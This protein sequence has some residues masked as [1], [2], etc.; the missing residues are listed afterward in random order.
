MVVA[1]AS[2]GCGGDDK[3]AA[4]KDPFTAIER[5]FEHTPASHRAAPHW[6]SL[7][8]LSGKTDAQP[9]VTVA[10]GAI[11]WRVRWTCR[12]GTF[13][14]VVD[15]R[16]TGPS[17]SQGPCPGH[18]ER[19][20]IGKGL[21]RLS[22]T[23][24]GSWRMEV[25]QQVDTPLHEPPLAAMQGPKAR[26]LKRGSFYGLEREGSGEVTLRRLSSGRLALRLEHFKT[27]ANAALFVWVSP[28]RHPR[29]TRQA[30]TQPHSVV[31][32]LKATIGDENYLLPRRLNPETVRSIVIWCEPVRVAY[33][34]AS[35]R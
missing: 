28:A 20:F 18:R 8:S 13:R 33:T 25:E 30:V 4:R 15:P 12:S 11:Q 19:D 29:T 32:R 26:V 10:A 9:S 5:D 2:T 22:V 31:A 34:A 35:L 27:S 21:R 17:S 14:V 3:P 24:A 6:V 7:A 23:A 16:P 1:A